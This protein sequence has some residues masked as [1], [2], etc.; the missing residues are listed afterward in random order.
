MGRDGRQAR[1][2][3]R[4]G[5]CALVHALAMSAREL[6][7]LGTA[8]QVPT[9]HRAHHAAFLAWDDVGVLFDPGEG[10]Q[11]QL[12]LAGV[13]PTRITHVCITHF[14][15]DHCL[16]L[17]GIAQRLSLDRVPH[18][19]HVLFPASGAIYY[20]RLVKASIYVEGATLVPVPISGEGLA[21][22]AGT[23]AFHAARLE[24]GVE[25]FGYRLEEPDGRTM[26]PERLA[27]AGVRGPD[28]GRL[29]REGS[30]AVAG[31]TV[32]RDEVSVPRPG[33]RFAFVMDTR[34]CDGARALLAGAD[35]AASECTFLDDDSQLAREYGHLTVG[36]A[37][38]MAREAGVRRL[39]LTHFSQRYVTL[40]SFRAAAAASHLDAVVCQDLQR[41]PVPPRRDAEPGSDG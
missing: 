8:S 23:L 29:Q 16:G 39:A 37:T 38:T 24:H 19:V 30:L 31:R 12:I 6:I 35:L 36:E 9:R 20:E 26:L 32:S 4:R 33:Q 11:R 1:P 27:A 13:S 25:C 40:D 14:H 15:G 17:A 18:P 21:H 22:D 3:T 34:P 5:G 10:T 28:V 7:I 2:V 41:V